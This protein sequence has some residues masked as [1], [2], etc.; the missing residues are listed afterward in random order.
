MLS[1]QLLKSCRICP[2]ECGVNRIEGESGF[3]KIAGGIKVA[4]AFLHFWEEPCISG[5]NGSGTVFFSGCNMGCVFCQNY[6]ISQMRFGAFIDVNKLATIF[7]NLQAKS[8]H[9]IN[10]VTPTIYVPYIIEAIDIARKNGLRVPI[11]YNTSSY[12]KP[13]TIELLKGYVDIFLPDLKYFDD[14]IAQKY[15]NAPQYFEFASKSILKMFEL[16]GDVVIENGIMKR[17][18]II[19]HLVLPMHA[20]DSIKVLSWI[21]DNLK[22]K[23]MLSLMSQYYPMYKAKEFK[24]ISRRITTRE[25]QKVVNFALENGLDYGY[26]QDKEVATDKYISEFDL[27]DI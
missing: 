19:R 16:V 17:G 18:V 4:K 20:N 27:E 22:G 5:K 10:L 6:E 12:E 13:E 3:C 25:Y 11:V 24:E 15:S 23:V 26:I 21:K 9:N 1:Q 7:L 14:E 8:A 2:R